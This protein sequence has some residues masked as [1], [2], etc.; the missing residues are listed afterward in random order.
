MLAYNPVFHTS[1]YRASEKIAPYG[2]FAN[3]SQ[4]AE[5]FN[6]KFCKHIL[7]FQLRFHVKE[8]STGFNNYKVTTFSV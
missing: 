8:N 1:I 6:I 2:F 3:L 4:T 7:R 5:N